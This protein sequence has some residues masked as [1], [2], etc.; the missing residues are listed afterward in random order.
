MRRFSGPVQSQKRQ[1]DNLALTLPLLPPF[2]I[3]EA[4]APIVEAPPVEPL[5]FFW[6]VP[7]QWYGLD[8]VRIYFGDIDPLIYI[9][10]ASRGEITYSWLEGTTPPFSIVIR[11]TTATVT[12]VPVGGQ[13]SGGTLGLTATDGD[14]SVTISLT[15]IGPT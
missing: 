6:T 3:I 4:A 15:I 1:P 2:V 11:G 13:L 7:E 12:L 14:E 10:V 5:T 8:R 9:A